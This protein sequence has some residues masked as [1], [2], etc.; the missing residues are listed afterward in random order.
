ML[1][2]SNSWVFASKKLVFASKVFTKIGFQKYS[3]AKYSQE[4]EI[5]SIRVQ[6]IS[7]KIFEK[8]FDWKVF[9]R[10]QLLSNPGFLDNSVIR[11]I[12]AFHYLS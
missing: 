6:S 12:Y 5:E 1:L 2:E 3:S 9:T 7:Q 8:V 10:F 11:T 4:K